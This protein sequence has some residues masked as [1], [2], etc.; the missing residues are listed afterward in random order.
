[1]RASLL[2][3]LDSLQRRRRGFRFYYLVHDPL[4]RWMAFSSLAM[5][6]RS[7]TIDPGPRTAAYR[8]PHTPSWIP[9]PLLPHNFSSRRGARGAMQH[10]HCRNTLRAEKTESRFER[11]GTGV[12]EFAAA[13]PVPTALQRMLKLGHEYCDIYHLHS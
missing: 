2:E 9:V 8:Y 13:H 1:M 11:N 10:A 4:R 7:L 12:A 6:P 5:R 3:P